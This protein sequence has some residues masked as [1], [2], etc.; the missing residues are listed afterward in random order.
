MIGTAGF[1]L[2]PNNKTAEFSFCVRKFWRNKGIGQFLLQHSIN[3]AKEMGINC[4]YGTIHF[5]NIN[6]I[7]VIKKSGFTKI[8]PPE[9]GEK[10]IFFELYFEK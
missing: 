7:H 10:E 8:T 2:N 1:F 6:T 4:F 9:V 5:Q 3:I